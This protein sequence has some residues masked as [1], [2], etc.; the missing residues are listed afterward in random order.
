MIN[1]V[2]QSFM[3]TNLR[4]SLLLFTLLALP[5]MARAQG[6]AF[7][8]QGR[9]NSD[10]TAATGVFDLTFTLFNVASGAG[11]VGT[12]VSLPLTPVTNGLFTATLDFGNQFPGA[13]RWLEITVR[14]N[15]GGAFTTLA[16]RQRLTATPYAI[17][18]SNITGLVPAA[19]LAGTYS[20]VVTLNNAGNSFS[21]SGAGLT[22]LNANNL[23][24][25][26]VPDARL[27][28]S[29]AR[30]N[31]V[32]QVAGNLGTTPG[33]DFLGTRDNQPLEIK[34]NGTR[35][36]RLEPT[37]LGVPNV[38]GGSPNNF[39]S[40]GVV[41][42]T[43]GGGSMLNIGASSD[44]STIAGGERN[45]IFL[46]ASH[47]A[48]GGGH[49]NVIGTSADHARIGGGSNNVINAFA[50]Y[51]LIGG[52]RN[53]LIGLASPFT[54][55]A[56]GDTN[57][58]ELSAAYST[59]SGGFNNTIR[60]GARS[61]TVAGGREHTVGQDSDY[62]VIAGGIH[63]TIG[64]NAVSAVI[65]GGDSNTSGTNSATVGGGRFNTSSGDAATT[66]GG[67]L[68]L[69][70]GNF[71][72]IGGGVFNRSTNVSATV[73]G[74]AQNTSGGDAATVGGGFQNVSS[75]AR[76]VVAG[77]EE[78]ISTEAYTT[79]GGGYRNTSS[80]LAATISGGRQNYNSGL[81]A[82]VGGGLENT[83][84]GSFATVPG[85]TLNRA[86]G[87]YSFAAGRRAK[88]DHQGAF[89]WAD[90]Q[91]LD[92]ASTGGDRFLI[93]AGGGVGLGATNLAGALTLRAPAGVAPN[94]MNGIDN[95]LALGLHATN[96]YKWIQSYGGSLILNPVGNNVGIGLTNPAS[97]LHVNGTVTATSFNPPSD[98][99]LKENFTGVSP[100]EVLEKVSALRI[101][102][103]NFKGDEATPHLGP[104]A[105]DF[106]AA[107][108]LGTDER[109]IAT[110]DAD[111][112]ALAAIQ[113][114]NQKVESEKQKA[115]IERQ[116]LRAENA[117]L[118][119]R[120]EK[121]ERLLLNR[122]GGGR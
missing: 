18:A 10:A 105:Q 40:A 46:T 15:G 116:T 36:L 28:T 49:F 23:A 88:A 103:W 110:V 113:G 29:V 92:F 62:S 118:K 45:Q 52:G 54:T 121:L 67:S 14:T 48:I 99:N 73:A 83:N 4:L 122:N 63:N 58:I 75:G 77:G 9:L 102:R 90:S 39:V 93:R 114:L 55:I 91:D 5:G 13:G 17:T 42:A 71:A 97:A 26:T 57:S 96:S 43:I 107:F 86:D 112:V 41:G 66:S 95:A 44:H 12:P 30:T 56:G 79:V 25:G 100:R 84:R 104:M 115:E 1:P 70:S 19:S 53:H 8:Y 31:Q 33:A 2:A 81:F 47:S 24:S 27:A 74:G 109:H 61:S 78:N 7:T 37:A 51:A 72:T 117:E 89:V 6:S 59:I 34:V 60:R 21:G 65:G 111:G 85:G 76:S 38:I 35:A 3:K 16:P 32:W 87:A 82:T 11:Q 94:G 101:T 69:S 119:A 120:L 68:N 22:S 106:H 80:N 108:G 64:S 20:S 98:R 50:A